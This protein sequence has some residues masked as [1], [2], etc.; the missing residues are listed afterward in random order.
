M[1]ILGTLMK[2]VIFATTVALG[3]SG[4]T[5][6]D[7]MELDGDRYF[8]I[9]QVFS[10]GSFLA[11]RCTQHTSSGECYGPA[12]FMP[13]G[14]DPMPYDDKIIHLDNPQVVDT[15]TYTNMKDQVKTVPVIVNKPRS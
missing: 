12:V 2:K 1:N 7:L 3:L 5:T 8:E 4:C 6:A 14:T 11:E 9:L 13:R 15:Y 10:D